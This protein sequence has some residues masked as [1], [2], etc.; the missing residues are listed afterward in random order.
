MGERG[1]RL[2]PWRGLPAAPRRGLAPS[3]APPPPAPPATPLADLPTHN[4]HVYVMDVSGKPLYWRHGTRA[5]ASTK[6]PVLIGFLGRTQQG[7][8]PVQ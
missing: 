2:P 5:Q 8:D 6:C 4:K 3:H 1:A 7:K